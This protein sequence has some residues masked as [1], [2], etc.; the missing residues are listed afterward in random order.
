VSGPAEGTLHAADTDG[1]PASQVAE[2]LDQA[3]AALGSLGASGPAAGS[4]AEI[5]AQ[6]HRLLTQALQARAADA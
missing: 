5:Y 3:R 6:V 4:D 2:L 1:L